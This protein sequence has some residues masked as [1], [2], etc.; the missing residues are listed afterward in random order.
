MAVIEELDEA[1]RLLSQLTP[2]IPPPG[3]IMRRNNALSEDRP[4]DNRLDVVSSTRSHTAT[5]AATAAPAPAAPSEV[6][7]HLRTSENDNITRQRHTEAVS[8][9][10]RVH[11][12]AGATAAATE[13]AMDARSSRARSSARF[14]R[15]GATAAVALRNS[16]RASNDTA[17]AAT[18]DHQAG[19]AVQR[20][21]TTTRPP[22]RC[23]NRRRIEAESGTRA[24]IRAGSV[25]MPAA[26]QGERE[27]RTSPRRSRRAPPEF[28]HRITGLSSSTSRPQ[29]H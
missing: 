24:A 2:N 11:E 4:C 18:A 21:A 10:V 3:L 16:N 8:S 6:G 15:V 27:V 5:P 22:S 23:V 12:G 7:L 20:G 25:T 28:H 9:S 14:T 19:T 17:T 13:R 29:W 26:M 1:R